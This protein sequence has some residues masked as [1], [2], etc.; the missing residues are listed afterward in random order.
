MA[1]EAVLLT[2][3]RQK[4]AGHI[5]GKETLKPITHMAFGDGGHRDDGTVIP[6]SEAQTALK[7][8][9]LRKPLAVVN[10]ED[11]LSATGSGV[12]EKDELVGKAISEAALVD[13]DGDVVAVKNFAPKLKEADERYDVSIRVRV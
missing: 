5:A 2:Q 6:P 1:A 11:L 9:I 13:G 4:V 8:E 10:Q 12:I 3:F 7:H